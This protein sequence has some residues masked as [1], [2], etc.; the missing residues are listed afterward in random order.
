MKECGVQRYQ[1]G[2]EFSGEFKEGARFNGVMRFVSGEVYSGEWKN[3]MFHG[4]GKI[5]YDS[6]LKYQGEFKDGNKHGMGLLILPKEVK[7]TENGPEI[8]DGGQYL[9]EFVA[10][11][12]HGNGQFNFADGS[13]YIGEFKDGV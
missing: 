3:G 4:S 11:Q 13:E 9:G 1:N 12:M 10:D 7:N 8:V 6:G 2:D 5:T